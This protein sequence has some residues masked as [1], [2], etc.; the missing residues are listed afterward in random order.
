MSARLLLIPCLLLLA[1]SARAASE[2]GV[3]KGTGS[4]TN[5]DQISAEAVSI[6]VSLTLTASAF[7]IH[8]CWTSSNQQDPICYD[9][10]YKVDDNQQ[11]FSNGVKIGDIYPGYVVLFTSNDQVS[12]QMIFN[13]DTDDISSA[14]SLRYIYTLVSYDG[15]SEGRRGQLQRS[16]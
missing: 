13:F 3:F 16:P 2:S 12:E 11:V 6:S 4:Y 14:Q 9:S 10:N 7:T 8:D 5:A 15:V 1:F